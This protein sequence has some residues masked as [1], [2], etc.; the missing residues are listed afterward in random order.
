MLTDE[1]PSKETRSKRDEDADR[2]VWSREERY[3]QR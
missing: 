2:N 1:R 3:D